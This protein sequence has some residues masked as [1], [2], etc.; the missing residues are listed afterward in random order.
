MGW[1]EGLTKATYKFLKLVLIDK[2]PHKFFQK[3][4]GKNILF[5]KKITARRKEGSEGLWT[6]M[7]MIMTRLPGD[8]YSGQSTKQSPDMYSP[9]ATYNENESQNGKNNNI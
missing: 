6:P 7:Q 2:R 4:G 9:S 3:E 1:H 8:W 5:A